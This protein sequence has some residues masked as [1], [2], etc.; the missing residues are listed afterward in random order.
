MKIFAV[1]PVKDTSQA[2]QR[3]ARMLPASVR[4]ELA[5]AMLRD[6]LDTLTKVPELAGVMVVTEDAEAARIAHAYYVRVSLDGARD[7]HTGAVTA[8]SRQLAS[9]GFGMMAMPADIPLVTPSDIRSVLLSHDE[10]PSF[11]IVPSRDLKGSNAIVCASADAVPLRYGSDSFYP[12][13]DAAKSVGIMPCVVM[14]PNIALDIDTPDDLAEFI[15][16]GSHTRANH[17]LSEFGA[18]KKAASR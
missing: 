1:V 9:E 15:A 6:V 11:T 16:A 3:L 17:L 10:A 4:Q 18:H 13:L 7:G 14:V 12:H 5:L 8:A 2:K